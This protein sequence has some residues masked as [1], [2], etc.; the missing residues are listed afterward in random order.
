MV[1]SNFA[2]NVGF[3]WNEWWMNVAVTWAWKLCIIICD[4][5]AVSNNAFLKGLVDYFKSNGWVKSA[6]E[7][8]GVEGIEFEQ[9][10][11]DAWWGEKKVRKRKSLKRNE[12]ESQRKRNLSLNQLCLLKQKR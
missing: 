4:G 6:Q 3:L 11:P 5:D 2:G 8:R 9:G 1:R 12:R 10:D 7:Y